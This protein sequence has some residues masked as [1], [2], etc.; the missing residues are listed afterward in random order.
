MLSKQENE[1]VLHI[2][3]NKGHTEVVRVL[4]ALV[5]DHNT[6]DKLTRMIDASG[7]T[8]L[9]KAMRSQHEDS[10][11]EFPPNYAQEM[12][13][14][15]AAESSFHDALINILE[16]CNNPT[17]AAGP[18]NKMPLHAAVIQEHKGP[19]PILSSHQDPPL[20]TST[21]NPMD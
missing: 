17:Y 14:Y 2:A 16:S 10:E 6:N 20:A 11:F 9:H 5:E 12:P 4:L 18:S 19:R 1:T 7:D 15:L 13:L 8:A 21:Y 3:A